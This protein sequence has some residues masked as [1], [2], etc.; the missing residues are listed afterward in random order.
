MSRECVVT[1]KKPMSGNNVSHAQNK[2]KRRF[3]PN[4]QS[5]RLFSETLKKYFR[6]R[7]SVAGMRTI[8]HKGGLDAFVTSTAP[9]K[10]SPELRKV[11]N[12]ID[13]AGADKKSA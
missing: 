8:D 3:M 11:R 9:S 2:T 10:L 13:A 12:E 1:G 7:V 4:L 6:L 5:V